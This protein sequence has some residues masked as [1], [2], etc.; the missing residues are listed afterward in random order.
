MPQPQGAASGPVRV[1]DVV[2]GHLN[3]FF[4]R[5]HYDCARVEAVGADWAVIRTFDGVA[6]TGTGAGVAAK[7]AEARDG[8]SLLDEHSSGCPKGGYR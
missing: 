4:G 5:D 3:G 1:G 7:L 8:E 6:V 2:H